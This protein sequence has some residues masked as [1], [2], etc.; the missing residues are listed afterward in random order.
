MAVPEE[1]LFQAWYVCSSS[2]AE[3]DNSFKLSSLEDN[4]SEISDVS[5]PSLSPQIEVEPHLFELKRSLKELS[6]DNE[7]ED[8]GEAGSS[9]GE[10]V[11]YANKSSV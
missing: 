6:I 9:R 5:E 8:L 3:S 1:E 7:V 4:F 10:R 11:G 2:V